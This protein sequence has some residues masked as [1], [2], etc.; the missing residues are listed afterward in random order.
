MTQNVVLNKDHFIYVCNSGQLAPAGSST[1]Q[2]KIE[3]DSQFTAVKLCYMADIAGAAQTD[4]TKVIP[5]VRVQIQD[6]GSGRNLQD[7]AV[8][9]D[10]LAGRGELPFVLPI[11]KIF[12]ANSSIKVTFTNYSAGTTYTNVEL[13][14]I[15]FKTFGVTK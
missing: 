11:P 4:S 3:A 7:V 13:A 10:S 6:S 1:Q 12:S 14:F 2:I 9:I 5:L 15:G 8:P